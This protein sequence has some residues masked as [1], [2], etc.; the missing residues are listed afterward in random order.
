M[1][2][3]GQGLVN[4]VFFFQVASRI[5]SIISI[6]CMDRAC[7]SRTFFLGG[8]MILCVTLYTIHQHWTVFFR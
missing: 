7:C 1:T 3:A 6:H 5:L 2:R 8:F 4:C